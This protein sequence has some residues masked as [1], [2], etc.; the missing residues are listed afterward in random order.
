MAQRIPVGGN[1][2]FRLD[3]LCD[4]GK[5]Q[6][7]EMHE[8]SAGPPFVAGF[9]FLGLRSPKRLHERTRSESLRASAQPAEFPLIRRESC[10]L[11]VTARQWSPLHLGATRASRLQNLYLLQGSRVR[12][13][14][15]KGRNR[16]AGL[17]H[18]SPATLAGR[19][20]KIPRYGVAAFKMPVLSK[21]TSTNTEQV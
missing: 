17:V 9:A 15:Q 5:S 14:S 20:P 11:R 12:D 10:E 7:C 21:P 18:D 2:H 6:I 16:K 8:I 19:R 3:S 13:G 4:F 1:E